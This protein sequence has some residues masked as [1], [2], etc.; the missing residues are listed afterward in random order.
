MDYPHVF[1]PLMVGPIR[2]ENRIGRSSHS[3]G[4]GQN[5]INDDFISYH[6]ARA[7]G[8]VGLTIL[9]A[10]CVH[11]STHTSVAIPAWSPSLNGESGWLVAGYHRLMERLEPYPM[12]VFQQLWHGGSHALPP[13]GSPPWSASALPSVDLGVMSQAMTKS[14]IDEMVASHATAAM[15]ATEGGLHGVEIHVAHGY[16]LHQFLTPLTNHRED[17][18]GGS[19]EN[20]LRFPLEVI[21]AVRA[22]V[23]P[24]LAVGVR[25][26]GEDA[27]P[28][29]LSNEDM[30]E[31]AE[32]LERTEL[33]DFVNLTL[34]TRWAHEKVL[35]PMHEPHGY[36]LPTSLPIARAL[37]LPTMVTG[38]ILTLAEAEDVLAEGDAQ[39]VSMV[40]ATIADPDLVRKSRE[41]KASQ[42]RPCIGCNH[43]CYAGIKLSVPRLGC[44]VNS[45]AGQEAVAGDDKISRA[46]MPRRALVIGGGPAGLEAA[47]VAALRGHSVTLWEAGM[48]LGGQVSLARLAPY[49]SD[50]GAVV[51]WM[52]RELARL[53]VDVR[54]NMRADEASVI[55]HAPDAVVLA[56]GGTPRTDGFQS[57][58]PV[59]PVAGL[60]EFPAYS[61]W[62]V[63]KGSP[64]L[65][66]AV[67]VVDEIGHYEA[68]AVVDKLFES[69]ETVHF[70][71]RFVT[72]AA[73]IEWSLSSR[74]ARGR[75]ARHD[76]AFHGTSFLA[77]VD[78]SEAVIG[79]LDADE[80]FKSVPA[81]D[82]VIASGAVPDMS[83]A[84]ALNKKGFA[85]AV[86]GDALGPRY[87]QTAIRE[88]HQAALA[89]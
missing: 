32:R 2:L 7:R 65:G 4:L 40:R 5:G 79:S 81:N 45:G 27:V 85:L 58:R 14:Q 59:T 83:L 38:R 50:I 34:G 57:A 24:E 62:D 9:E 56:T 36:E 88:G 71:T 17:S 48:K 25:L 77:S 18:Y 60:D 52:E 55:E 86:V 74:A 13:D 42:V 28:G 3:T 63:M 78:G 54:L 47:R 46:N 30:V 89:I 37:S 53:D 22:A 21:E 35:A 16:L 43:G 61:T 69:V 84:E 66:P 15:R 20:R 75:F 19:L 11:P 80:L 6:E 23:G 73:Q 10:S 39:I 44:A 67:V 12:R 87:L 51:D 41:G 76:F 68:I 33:L 70:V 1:R 8:G 72:L 82:T 49:R 26:N 31:I 64:E 29:G